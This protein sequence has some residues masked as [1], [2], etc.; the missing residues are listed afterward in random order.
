MKISN[1]KIEKLSQN[2]EKLYLH[3]DN[4]GT[5]SCINENYN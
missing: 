1:K 4:N 5:I 3:S 2:N